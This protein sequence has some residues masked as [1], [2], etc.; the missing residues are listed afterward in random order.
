MKAGDMVL[1][2]DGFIGRPLTGLVLETRETQWS[3]SSGDGDHILEVLV[4]LDRP[5]PSNYTHDGVESSVSW[6]FEDLLQV[7][8]ETG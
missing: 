4:L 1:L 8:N 6:I 2:D 3:R 7:I 5:L